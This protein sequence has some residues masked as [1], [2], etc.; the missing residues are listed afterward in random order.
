MELKGIKKIKELK[1][2]HSISLY[3]KLGD[4][5]LFAS[6]GGTAVFSV[7]LCNK[8]RSKLLADVRRIEKLLKIT[9]V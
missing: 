8:D 2:F 4:K 3:K 7:T 1:S 6:H 5:S 9:V